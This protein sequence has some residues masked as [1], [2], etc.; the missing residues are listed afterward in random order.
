M[1]LSA[2]I[3]RND[4]C[5]VYRPRVLEMMKDTWNLGGV[6]INPVLTTRMHPT[7]ATLPT[8]PGKSFRSLFSLI[9][10]LITVSTEINSTQISTKRCWLHGMSD[11]VFLA[12]QGK[13]LL[14]SVV[15]H[16]QTPM[17]INKKIYIAL[18]LML[19]SVDQFEV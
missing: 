19:F 15:Q 14:L 5:I 1:L 18:I 3:W 17:C 8:Q 16:F 11:A 12:T 10:E 9:I 4:G 7:H 6:H 2:I 13:N